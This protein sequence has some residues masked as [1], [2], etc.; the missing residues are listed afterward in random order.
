MIKINVLLS[1]AFA[2]DIDKVRNL[3]F[4]VEGSGFKDEDLRFRGEAL[5]V[6]FLSVDC[7]VRSVRCRNLGLGIGDKDQGLRVRAYIRQLGVSG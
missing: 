4:I 2:G 3:G 7:R 5:G 6:G 1:A